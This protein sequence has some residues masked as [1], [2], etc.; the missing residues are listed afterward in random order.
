MAAFYAHKWLQGIPAACA[1]SINSRLSTPVIVER[2]LTQLGAHE[3]ATRT[4][5]K[6]TSESL[7]RVVIRESRIITEFIHE[8][9]LDKGPLDSLILQGLNV[10]ALVATD[11]VDWSYPLEKELTVPIGAHVYASEWWRHFADDVRKHCQNFK[12]VA[13]VQGD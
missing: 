7:G 4:E 13:K 11:D 3:L 12:A 2:T 9:K 1:F 8:L 6:M 10:H 5:G